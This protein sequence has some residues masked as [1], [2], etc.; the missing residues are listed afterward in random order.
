MV[1][2]GIAWDHPRGYEP[3]RACS[4]EFKKKHPHIS[5]KWDVRSLKD[6]GDRPLED[7][8]EDYDL[9]TVDHPYMG[10]A[11]KSGLLVPLDDHISKDAL[12][13]LAMQSVGLSFESYVYNKLYAL[14]IDAAA[15]VAAYKRVS[16]EKLNLKL[17]GT[18]QELK[19]FYKKLPEGYFVT[20][21]LCSVDAIC[22]FLT[23]GA[24][25]NPKTFLNRRTLNRKIAV[26]VIDELKYHLHFLHP[27]SI[28]D[29]P[30]TSLNRMVACENIIYSPFLFGYTNY[31]RKGVKG[32]K[33]TFHNSPTLR[34]STVSTLLGG[35]GIAVSSYS[36][37]LEAAVSFAK[38][39]SS[40]EVQKD[41][42]VKNGGQPG[43]IRAW[44]DK[45]ND[46]IC[47]NFFS[48]T[49]KTMENAYIR[50][51]YPNWNKFQEESGYLLHKG[52]K[53]HH[54]SDALARKL[55]ELFN[56]VFNGDNAI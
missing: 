24:Q 30:I 56:S 21:P 7:L 12:T 25:E 34:N 45:N 3:L 16:F 11:D 37:Y 52:L 28:N 39:V 48:N 40:A 53:N 43:N 23:L 49:L 26:K 46:E 33:I 2:K 44:L 36:K 1:L 42:Y 5:I 51:K 29:N 6:F 41:I 9:I 38:F 17:P 14:P 50:P 13:S 32:Q 35:V 8:V 18:R 22:S 19:E 31:S 10:H 15:Q 4:H 27:E 20:W 55:V 47:G 54:D